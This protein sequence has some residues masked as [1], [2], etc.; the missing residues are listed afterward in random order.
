MEWFKYDIRQMTDDEY[1]KWYSL[2]SVGKKKRVDSFF[3]IDDK[4]RTVAG[5]MLA[6]KAIAEKCNVLPEEIE[7]TADE[8]GKPAVRNLPV[9]L[10]ISHSGNMAVCVVDDTPVGIDVEQLRPVE[11][12][13]AKRFFNADEQIYLFGREP[14]E[15]DFCYSD[16]DGVM[17]R[18]FEIWTAKEAFVK[19]TG[20]GLEDIGR[21]VEGVNCQKFR[22][23]DYLLTI[24]SE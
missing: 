19:Y 12:K 11:L 20:K 24:V 2:L 16:D 22:F 8:Y 10:S 13:I 9:H 3:Y 1:S 4:K 18:F 17:L 5:E 23:D 21:P 15:T 7:F 14:V 6:R